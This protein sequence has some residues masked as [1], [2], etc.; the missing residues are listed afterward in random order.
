MLPLIVAWKSLRQHCVDEKRF[1][2]FDPWPRCKTTDSTELGSGTRG[3]HIMAGENYLYVKRVREQEAIML[4][5][6]E[7]RTFF[8]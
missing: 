5:L 1:V 3:S 7:R 6:H 2:R 8:T 4:Y